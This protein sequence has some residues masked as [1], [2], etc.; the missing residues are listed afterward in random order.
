M[1]EAV[2]PEYIYLGIF[3]H[4]A[5]VTWIEVELS[6]PDLSIYRIDILAEAVL[7]AEGVLP[8]E[9]VEDDYTHASHVH[10]L[11]RQQETRKGRRN[12]E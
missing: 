8:A 12:A 10:R 6:F 11:S 3:R 9:H 2:T 7:L 1:T 5:P 4:G